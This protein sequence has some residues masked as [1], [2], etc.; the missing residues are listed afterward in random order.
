MNSLRYVLYISL[1]SLILSSCGPQMRYVEIE[2]R[3]EQEVALPFGK[4]TAVFAI[5]EE[6]AD[7]LAL[8]AI[9]VGLSEKLEADRALSSGSVGVFSIPKEEFSGFAGKSEGM[10]AADSSY[11]TSLML[12]TGADYLVFLGDIYIYAINVSTSYGM[13]TLS[14]PYS[15][16]LSVCDPMDHTLI[17]NDIVSDT[18][19]LQSDGYI[20]KNE[21]SE[22]L[23]EHSL[24]IARSIG[25]TLGAK[26]SEQWEMQERIIACYDGNSKWVQAFNY[27]NMFKW[28]EA[29]DIWMQL[30]NTN[31]PRKAAFAAFNIAVGC[32]IL[33]QWE[34]A[35]EW[36]DFA[37]SNYPFAQ[38]YDLKQYIQSVGK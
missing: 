8:S 6:S 34:L 14:L 21:V 29:I 4:S 24:D 13:T 30:V 12:N 5:V 28:Q 26:L 38:A 3:A 22:T 27:A 32:E 37:I 19:Y 23:K 18:I 17:Y 7:S 1:C 11:I 25:V 16:R 2:R 20:A 31:N 9:G 10:H 35:E 36:V 33:Q 15:V